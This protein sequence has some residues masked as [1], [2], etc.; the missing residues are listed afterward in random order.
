VRH[1]LLALAAFVACGGT[2]VTVIRLAQFEPIR[3]GARRLAEQRMLVGFVAF[4]CA[5]VLVARR[6]VWLRVEY[7]RSWLLATP[8]GAASYRRASAIR[9]AMAAASVLLVAMVVT[10]IVA[11]FAGEPVWPVLTWLS[12]GFVVGSLAGAAWPLR[13]TVSRFEDSRYTLKWRRASTHPSLDALA[14]WPISKAMAWYRPEQARTL[15]LVAALSF[16]AG[17]SAAT[18]LAVLVAWLLASYMLTLMRAVSS[19]SREA[20]L[21]LR[22]TVLPFRTFAWTIG[23][24]A[25]LHQVA[26]TVVLAAIAGVFGAAWMDAMYYGALWLALYSMASAVEIRRGYLGARS[27]GRT[28][29]AIALALAAESR[30]RGAGALVAVAVTLACSGALR[31]ERA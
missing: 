20:A 17:M 10:A 9:L 22:P 6:R 16:P 4:F 5:L 3:Q 18:S 30:E 25:L 14:R 1:G 29:V 27:A 15:F 23:K 19:V 2:I 26:C 21:W 7:E 13:T 24:Q 31:R 28:F 8:I 12:G 11:Y